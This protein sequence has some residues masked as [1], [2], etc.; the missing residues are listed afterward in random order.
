MADEYLFW[1]MSDFASPSSAGTDLGSVPKASLNSSIAV[2]SWSN[3]LRATPNA[4]WLRG[5][6]GF[7]RVAV[8]SS[9]AARAGW[10]LCN[11]ARD[12]LKWASQELGS[13]RAAD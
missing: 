8:R 5:F 3:W 11:R 4:M 1:A 7:K 10:L 6:L 2:S 13:K 9:R 12:R